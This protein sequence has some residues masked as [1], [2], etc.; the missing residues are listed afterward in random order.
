MSDGV[1][2]L[3]VGMWGLYATHQ[4]PGQPPVDNGRR[5][6]DEPPA[7]V[8]TFVHFHK[9]VRR[10]TRKVSINSVVDDSRL[11]CGEDKC[12]YSF[13]SVIMII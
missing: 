4:G 9:W 2:K 3:S 11:G 6:A 10:M 8:V 12:E 5:V 1:R 7:G 13:A